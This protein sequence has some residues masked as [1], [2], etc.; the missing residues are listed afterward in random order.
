MTTLRATL[1]AALFVAIAAWRPALAQEPPAP[2]QTAPDS[3]TPALVALGDSVFHG[4]VGRATCFACHGAKGVGGLAPPLT[5]GTWLHSDGSYA[6][7]VR[8]VRDG[9]LKPSRGP[10]PMPPMGGV[11]LTPEQLRAVAAYVYTL[12]HQGA[13]AGP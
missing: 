8:V 9:V 4:R 1:G 2:P 12:G 3:I 5:S 6:S 11:N 13:R 10:T 7:I